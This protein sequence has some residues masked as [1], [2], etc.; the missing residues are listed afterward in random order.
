MHF[1]YCISNAFLNFIALLFAWV[2]IYTDL[3]LHRLDC[4]LYLEMIQLSSLYMFQVTLIWRNPALQSFSRLEVII[5][6]IF[7]T[8]FI[9]YVML[10][11]YVCS[12]VP[13]CD[14]WVSCQLRHTLYNVLRTVKGVTETPVSAHNP[15]VKSGTL[16]PSCPGIYFLFLVEKTSL[17]SAPAP[18]NKVFIDVR[19]IY[20]TRPEWD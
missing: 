14:Q 1:S 18:C 19:S 10:K 6:V 16:N 17:N 7:Q 15:C 2:V 11:A 20:S 12:F 13:F 4:V 9:L 8:F 3:S 5:S